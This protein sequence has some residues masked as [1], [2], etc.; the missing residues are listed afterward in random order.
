M[1]NKPNIDNANITITA[2]VGNI[3]HGCCSHTD[4]SDPVRPAITPTSI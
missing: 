2:E 3:T 1:L 4:N